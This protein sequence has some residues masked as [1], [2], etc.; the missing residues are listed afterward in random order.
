MNV[1]QLITLDKSFL[2]EQVSQISNHTMLLVE[3]GLGLVLAL[4][5]LFVT[6][7][8]ANILTLEYEFNC[9]LTTQHLRLTSVSN[10]L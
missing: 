3:N 7:K 1:S 5:I 2:T 8:F 6:S 10:M 9:C 4:S